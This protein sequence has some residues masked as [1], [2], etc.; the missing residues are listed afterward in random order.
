MDFVK[1]HVLTADN[2]L[3]VLL[4]AALALAMHAIAG[5]EPIRA[6]AAAALVLYL[7]EVTQMQTRLGLPFWRGW[8]LDLHRQMEWAAPSVVLLLAAWGV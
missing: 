1:R 5:A 7:R 2:G 4:G 8:G 6:A 3:H